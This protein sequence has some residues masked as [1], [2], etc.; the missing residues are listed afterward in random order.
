MTETNLKLYS[1]PNCGGS[2]V[3]EDP[4]CLTFRHAVNKVTNRQ[5]DPHISDNYIEGLKQ[6][7][8]IFGCGAAFCL[9]DAKEVN[10]N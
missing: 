1:C 2:F 4:A 10:E 5:V 3:V 8:L 6:Q 7:D 9:D